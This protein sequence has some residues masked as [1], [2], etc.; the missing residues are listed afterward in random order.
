MFSNFFLVNKFFCVDSAIK[1]Y[2]VKKVFNFIFVQN[3]KKK[4]S[5]VAY[6][7]E[8][9]EILSTALTVCVCIKL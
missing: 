9:A 6:F 1:T 4:P 8:I 2:N 7:S 5:K 3:M